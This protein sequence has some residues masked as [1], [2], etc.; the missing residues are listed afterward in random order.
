MG[1]SLLGADLGDVLGEG[2]PEPLER[3]LRRPR[4]LGGLPAQARRGLLGVQR[5]GEEDQD[6][7]RGFQDR[8]PPVKLGGMVIR[9]DGRARGQALGFALVLGQPGP[10]NVEHSN[11][12]VPLL[13]IAEFGVEVKMAGPRIL[14][15]E[16]PGVKTGLKGVLN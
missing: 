2:A 4:E 16:R 9:L 1:D 10:H 5:E 13:A 8:A 15:L 7:G 11:C 12:S 14:S 3:G 6:A